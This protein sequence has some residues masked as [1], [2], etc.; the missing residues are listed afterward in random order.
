MREPLVAGIGVER[1]AVRRGI[2]RKLTEQRH[3]EA[4]GQRLAPA[5]AEHVVPTPFAVG[6]P[7]HVLDHAQDR[8]LDLVEHD[9]ALADVG[10]R[11]RLRGW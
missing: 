2:E 8:H 11:Q 10:E 6:E 3:A 9:D 1:A 5:F 7:G 4:L